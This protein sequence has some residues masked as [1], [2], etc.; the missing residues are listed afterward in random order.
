MDVVYRIG[1]AI[2]IIVAALF[3]VLVFVTGKGDAMSGGSGIRTTFR[4]KANFEDLMSR[5]ILGLGISFMAL[6]LL[7]DFISGRIHN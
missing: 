7:L 6:M 3:A 5:I 1:I 2:A 4:G